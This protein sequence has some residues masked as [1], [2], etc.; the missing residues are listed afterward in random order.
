MNLLGLQIEI[1]LFGVEEQREKQIK[2]KKKSNT[3]PKNLLYTLII[4]GFMRN[5]K[6]NIPIS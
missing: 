3:N 5:I 1:S 2:K 6:S 4:V